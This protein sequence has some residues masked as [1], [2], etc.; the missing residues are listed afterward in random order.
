MALSNLV[1]NKEQAPPEPFN[2]PGSKPLPSEK[3]VVKA[4]PSILGS[5]DMTSLYVMIIFFITNVPT[6]VGGGPAGFTYLGLGALLFFFPCIVATAQLGVLMPHEGS[7]YNWTHK[8]FGGYWG[9]FVAFCAWFPGV[10]VM[11]ACG[12]G[13]VGF[14]SGLN[15]AWL[16]EPWQQGLAISGIIAVAGLLATLRFRSL[17]HAVNVIVV[18]IFGV[19]LLLLIALVVYF[20]K[21]GHSHTVFT[22]LGDWGVYFTGGKQNINLFGLITLAYL[23]VEIPM[24]L[25]GEIVT[26]EKPG[27]GKRR[28][29]T[30]HLFW[31]SILV[32]AGYGISTLALLVIQGPANGSMYMSV[33]VTIGQVLGP[34]MADLTVI[35]IMAF[36]VMNVAVY[37]TVYARLL[38]VAAIDKHI[39]K[40]AGKLNRYRQPSNA[41]F[42][43]TLLAILVTLLVFVFIP[44]FVSLHENAVTLSQQVYNIMQAS[45]TLVW[46][47]STF[48]LFINLAHFMQK[49]RAAFQKQQLFPSWVLTL[50][51][52]L[53]AF[54]SIAAIVCTLMFSWIASLVS[55]GAW[56]LI[57]GIGTV[58]L[59]AIAGV[60]AA[61]ASGE[62][63]WEK[64]SSQKF[65]TEQL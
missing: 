34:Q 45:V 14:L 62:A 33:V 38:L 60:G 30:K 59:L 64:I 18:L 26:A 25:G 42:F 41:I 40:G 12:V 2:P 9:F 3:Y 13:V 4:M 65:G 46:A 6:V 53:G 49:H 54:G 39:P 47:I 58:L 27:Q 16:Q 48:F 37:N 15:S 11:V 31:G 44:L 56:T 10:L 63:L 7:L 19:V 29:I 57:V 61:L 36:F 55:N 24:T 43:Q 1:S 52:L 50:A 20:L 17:Q 21:G 32:I 51:S 28:V 8:A 23:G 5:F 35:I 22:N